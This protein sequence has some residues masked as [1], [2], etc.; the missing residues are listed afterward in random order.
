MKSSM[1]SLLGDSAHNQAMVHWSGH[2]NSV[3]LILTKLFD[4]NLGTV[5]DSSLWRSV[6]LGSSYEKLNKRMDP[7][8][9]L[10]YLYVCPSNKKKLLLVVDPDVERLLVVSD[11]EGTSFHSRPISFSLLSLLFHPTH[12]D[13]ILAYCQEQRLF[14]SKDFGRSWKFVHEFVSPGRFYWSVSGLDEDP[15]LLHLEAQDTSG[16]L[17]YMTCLA[18]SCDD[19]RVF[20]FSGRVDAGS[21]VVQDDYVFVQVTTVGPTKY[22]VSYR[23]QPFQTIQLPKYCLPKDMHLISTELHVLAGVQQW[24]ER[25]TYSLYISDQ[26]GE[27]Y[28]AALTHVRTTRSL[29][30]ALNMDVY[31]VNGISGVLLAN[32]VEEGRVRTFISFSLGQSW[33]P[34]TPPSNELQCNSASCSLHLHLR[35]SESPYSPDSIISSQ[36]APGLIIA[37]GTVGSELTNQNPRTFLSSDAGNTWRQVFDSER[38]VWFLDEGGTLLAV[39]QAGIPSSQLWVSSDEGQTWLPFRFS[40]SPLYIDGVLMEQDTH[41][42]IITIFGHLGAHS[43]WQL[44]KVD[45]NSLLNTP[46]RD[47]DYEKWTLRNQGEAC[48]M[49][50]TH[51]FRK[52]RPGHRCIVGD[53]LKLP[54]N[55]CKCT[56]YDYEWKVLTNGCLE[57]SS[58][59]FRPTMH[60]CGGRP[61]VRISTADNKLMA[62][63]HTNIT[64]LIHT[65]E[66][67]SGMDVRLDV[68][69]VEQV[70]LSAAPVVLLGQRTNLTARVLPTAPRTAVYYWWLDNSTEPVVTLDP[71]LVTSFGRVGG[72]TVSLQVAAGGGVNQDTHT[73]RVTEVFR[74]LQLSFSANLELHNP[75]IPEWRDDLARVVTETISQVISVPSEQ[76]LV[77]VYAGSP[78]AAEVFMLPPPSLPGLQV[79]SEE[80]PQQKGE[81]GE[82][83]MDVACLQFPN[84][85]S[86]SSPTAGIETETE[87]E[88][89]P[90]YQPH[91]HPE[92]HPLP[93][94]RT[95][96]SS[97]PDQ[98]PHCRP[99]H[100]L[101]LNS[102]SDPNPHSKSERNSHSKPDPNPHSSPD[103][104]PHCKPEHNPHSGSDANA[105]SR[106]EADPHCSS[107]TL[108]PRIRVSCSQAS[109]SSGARLPS[110]PRASH[111]CHGYSRLERQ[112][113]CK[114]A[115]LLRLMQLKGADQILTLPLGL[116]YSEATAASLVSSMKCGL[117]PLSHAALLLGEAAYCS[118]TGS[119]VEEEEELQ[120]SMALMAKVC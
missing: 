51:N 106:P 80:E 31:K 101:L 102:R 85:G 38:R 58:E 26:Q 79:Q 67:T 13:W 19:S 18:G 66:M 28:S 119:D 3:I 87:T 65:E 15:S 39:P 88:A 71:W 29:A 34:L 60:Q 95:T 25:D 8:L 114:L 54:A 69:A 35:M 16:L 46:C 78:T 24:D 7:G 86:S 23:R 92:P 116:S 73:I 112:N 9:V 84:C 41:H 45:Y 30:G 82:K 33:R 2:N 105:Q 10:S 96:H 47:K 107:S 120:R 44:I 32:R 63:T 93:I 36:H 99:D 70:I 5:T 72:V 81:Q 104:N 22:F 68:G 100:N 118:L 62:S 76:L 57:S 52:R 20:P 11:D 27:Y 90:D 111:G 115:A 75:A 109:A 42:H 43:D 110:L 53:Q 12:D 4:F 64:F 94:A 77:C 91:P 21:L 89:R 74:S 97:G 108:P 103:P 117:L 17:R 56:P 1:F 37:T 50:R 83:V 61:T 59:A 48:V 6:D 113:R 49:G 98:N 14:F 40:E 55:S